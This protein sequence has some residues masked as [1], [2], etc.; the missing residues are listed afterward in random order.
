F[1]GREFLDAA[2]LAEPSAAGDAEVA[3][4][5]RVTP[6]RHEVALAGD[7]QGVDGGL[8]PLPRR[9]APH[10]EHPAPGEREASAREPA[11]GSVEEG[12][13]RGRPQVARGHAASLLTL[14]ARGGYE[15]GHSHS[16]VPG[17]FEVTSS[18][19]RFTSRTSFV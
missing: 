6:G 4:P 18:T 1:D 15:A 5:L 11:D 8:A 9:P 16:M 7:P 13:E 14:R 10:R 19:T 17:G 3:H 12:V 2:T